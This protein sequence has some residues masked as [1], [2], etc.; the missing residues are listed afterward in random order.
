MQQLMQQATQ[1][2]LLLALVLSGPT[3][4]QTA[5]LDKREFSAKSGLVRIKLG[6]SHSR[7]EPVELSVRLKGAGKNAETPGEIISEGVSIT[8]SRFKLPP[9]KVRR[10]LISFQSTATT[11]T[12]YF[13]C[14]IY[15]PPVERMDRNGLAGGS[16]LLA[17]ES[18]SRFW[19]IP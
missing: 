9:N 18:C 14:V 17:T 4:A 12:P 16:M 10:L 13:A 8:P 5:F 15:Q 7:Q 3:L 6:V 1:C 19:V 11:R 2:G